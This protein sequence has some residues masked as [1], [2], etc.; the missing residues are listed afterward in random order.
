MS[1]N[2][3][4]QPP[5]AFLAALALYLQTA[6]GQSEADCSGPG[7]RADGCAPEEEVIQCS[8]NGE[9][10]YIYD[11]LYAFCEP[12]ANFFE[13]PFGVQGAQGPMECTTTTTGTHTTTSIKTRTVTF[14]TTTRGLAI[15]CRD[16]CYENTHLWIEKC[17]W[18]GC[19]SCGE[20]AS[21]LL[22]S[23][24]PETTSA[25][26][27]MFTFRPIQRNT[28]LPPTTS[29]ASGGQSGGSGS[30]GG[31]AP[32]FDGSDGSLE[33]AAQ[34]DQTTVQIASTTSAQLQSKACLQ[35]CYD[36]INYIP[37][38]QLCNWATC[39]LCPECS[40]TSVTA[41]STTVPL[42]VTAT[43]STTLV[44]VTSA[45]TTSSTTAT[46][47]ITTSTTFTITSTDTITTTIP[48]RACEP[49]NPLL[50]G[51]MANEECK[52][53]L[54]TSS[55]RD[56]LC[57]A[58]L[59]EHPCLYTGDLVLT[60]PRGNTVKRESVLANGD[61]QTKCRICGWG[62]TE[63][64]D[65]DTVAGNMTVSLE[66]GANALLGVINE[67]VIFGYG[68]FLAD[69]CS[70]PIKRDPVGYVEKMDDHPFDENCCN[71]TKYSTTVTFSVPPD[72]YS[73]RLMVR[74][75]TTLGFLPVGE[76]TTEI[77]DANQTKASLSSA[78]RQAG[79]LLSLLVLLTWR[80]FLE[81]P[82]LPNA[83]R[84]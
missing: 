77:W 15:E 50:A 62:G 80:T 56:T 66:F 63:W 1:W 35:L 81:P 74:P 40:G 5:F 27:G 41:T 2:G 53:N 76:V 58:R 23:T 57:L 54:S 71:S 13:S 22:P 33:E 48:L 82:I 39:V 42:A 26:D 59:A 72:L 12:H 10:C 38:S 65:V 67:T 9:H 75:N 21:I 84:S 18:P 36:A 6:Y 34:S 24:E 11:A 29:A 20:C 4:W 31:S 69:N 52:G 25:A 32:V 19:A 28:T 83:N 7:P 64:Q 49:P 17:G 51:I 30:G 8:R 43:V 47:S 60:C 68:I 16:L 45:M 61:Y 70:R 37:W 79:M 46:R 78:N 3:R 44:S 14:Y 73:V 55:Q